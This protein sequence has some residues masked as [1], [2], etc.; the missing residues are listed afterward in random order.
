MPSDIPA[1]DCPLCGNRMRI[2]MIVPDGEREH[3]HFYCFRC[4]EEKVVTVE[5]K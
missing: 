1:P 4:N 2:K 5:R 3:R